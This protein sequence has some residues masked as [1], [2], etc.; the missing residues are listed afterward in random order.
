MY[1]WVYNFC[2]LVL[3]KIMKKKCSL[4]P[5]NH[6]NKCT[7]SSLTN[8]PSHRIF[9][10][11]SDFIAELFSTRL[12]KESAFYILLLLLLKLISWILKWLLSHIVN[13]V[14]LVLSIGSLCTLPPL[15]TS[16]SDALLYG[17][18]LNYLI[19]CPS[20]KFPCIIFITKS[21]SK[22]NLITIYVKNIY[23]NKNNQ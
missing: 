11:K 2:H 3:F 9:L 8:S 19:L 23:K 15:P 5:I 16:P 4:H 18:A 1:S 10:E 20:S 6:V 12:W 22:K 17:S 21:K 14:T 13:N 7:G